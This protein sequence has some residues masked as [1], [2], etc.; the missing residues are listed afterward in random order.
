TNGTSAPTV[1]TL[2][3]SGIGST[4]A[5]L[6]AQV[7]DTGGAGIDE[8]RTSG[9]T[10]SSISAG[11][12]SAVTVNGNAF[13]FSLTGLQPGQTEYFQAWAHNPAASLFPYT[14]LFRSTNGTSAPTVATL[15]ASGIGSTSATLNAQVTDT[16]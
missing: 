14:T 15:S 16:G 7:T 6:N 8:D 9:T 12:T 13:S 4:S 5:T 11:S 10:T 3:A 1:A 2:S